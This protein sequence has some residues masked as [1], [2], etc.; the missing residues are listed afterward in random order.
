MRLA[1]VKALWIHK[2]KVVFDVGH[3]D[4]VEIFAVAQL[5]A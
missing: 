2:N 5:H 1:I 3:V 4:K